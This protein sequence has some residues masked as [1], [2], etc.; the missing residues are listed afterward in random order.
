[1][2]TLRDAKLV[3]AQGFLSEAQALEA[4]GVRD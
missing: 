2:I 3:K 1:V 4:A